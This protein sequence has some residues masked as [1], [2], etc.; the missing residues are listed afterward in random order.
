MLIN[1][2]HF[3]DGKTHTLSSDID[4]AGEEYSSSVIR[5]IKDCHVELKITDYDSIFRIEIHLKSNVV[6]GC[7][8]TLEDVDYVV[9]TNDALDFTNEE[10]DEDDDVLIQMTSTIIDL[11]PYVYSMIMA[12]I[13][14]KVVKKGAVPPSNGSGYRVISEEQFEKEKGEKTDSRWNVLDDIEL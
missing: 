4:F 7:A 12:A 14:L 2:L 11:K 13:P 5:R 6:V 1:R 10:L 9:K 3:N 8:Y